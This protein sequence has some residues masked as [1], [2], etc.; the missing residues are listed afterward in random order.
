MHLERSTHCIL[1]VNKNYKYE[2]L[3]VSNIYL[4]K[5]AVRFVCFCEQISKKIIV[6]LCI[7]VL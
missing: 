1:E 3:K 7:I 5:T 2:L 6:I 4:R